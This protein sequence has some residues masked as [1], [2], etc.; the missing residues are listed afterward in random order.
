MTTVYKVVRISDKDGKAISVRN[1]EG[2][3]AA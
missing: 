3:R 2:E 1:R